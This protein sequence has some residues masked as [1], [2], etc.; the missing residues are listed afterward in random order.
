MGTGSRA[1]MTGR[2]PA[3]GPSRGRGRGRCRHRQ[4]ADLREVDR[5]DR[6]RL[7]PQRLE[8]RDGGDLAV[9]IGAHG[10]RHADPA[11]GQPGKADED[12]ERAD[13]VDEFLHARRPVPRIA[14]AHAGVGEKPLCLRLKRGEV[15]VVRQAEP[16]L[17]LEERAGRKQA[18]GLQRV[19]PHD[20]ARAER[21]A[22]RRAV[23]LHL[24]HG[25]KLEILRAEADGV[26][27][28]QRQPVDQKPL[29][30]DAGQTVVGQRVGQRHRG[31]E[32][33]LTIDR[34]GP[35]DAAH[36]G[37]GAVRVAV[38]IDD[39]HGAEIDGLGHGLRDAVH[40]GAFVIGGEAVGEAHLRIAAEDRG[41]FAA[42]TL[43]DRLAHAAHRGDGGDAERE[44]GEEDAEAPRPPRSS[45]PAMRSATLTPPP[46]A[47]RPRRCGRRAGGSP[48]RS[49]R[50]AP[51]RG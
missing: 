32:H 26:A 28:V 11:H 22:A 41:A 43:L 15:G 24:Q 31:V 30:D 1:S 25:A 9:E 34:I 20:A 16:V 40:V 38:G 51:A 37:Q 17:R 35:V 19:E 45:R 23:G 12:E 48:G 36:L 47:G 44:T 18:G 29:H 4:K 2:A 5:E 10:S 27:H 39:D 13:P 7:G 42:Q 8:R 50:Q 14:P 46:R 3:A 21:E 49:G 6:P 33:D